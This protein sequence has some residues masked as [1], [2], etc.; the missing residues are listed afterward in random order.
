MAAAERLIMYVIAAY[1]LWIST[2]TRGVLTILRSRLQGISAMMRKVPFLSSK[3][4]PVFDIPLK[5][6]QSAGT[7]MEHGEVNSD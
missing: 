4:M 6:P 2:S 3:I 5:S 1:F 7:L